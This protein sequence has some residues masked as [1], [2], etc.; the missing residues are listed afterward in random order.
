MFL[1]YLHR[2]K[3]SFMY[4]VRV[5]NFML[6]FQA[7]KHLLIGCV[8]TAVTMAI[9]LTVRAAITIKPVEV[10]LHNMRWSDA[11]PML[12]VQQ[13]EQDSEKGVLL[14][15]LQT[16]EEQFFPG[17][18]HVFMG[19]TSTVYLLGSWPQ[20]SDRAQSE[21][22]VQL[23]EVRH[24]RTLTRL[25]L[26][27]FV[28]E[29]Y[30]VEENFKQ[31]YLLFGVK[32]GDR[33]S[34]CVQARDINVGDAPVCDYVQAPEG[35]LATWNPMHDHE[36]VFFTQSG[37]ILVMDPWEGIVQPV[38][39][40]TD[41]D[42][43]EQLRGLFPSGISD[44][45]GSF[46]DAAYVSTNGSQDASF[47]TSQTHNL[48]QHRH[49][50]C[51]PAHTMRSG[52]MKW[53]HEEKDY[54]VRLP[55]SSVGACIRDQWHAIVRTDDRVLL[56]ELQPKQELVNR[57]MVDAVD[58]TEDQVPAPQSSMSQSA[59]S[60]DAQV[61]LDVTTRQVTLLEDAIPPDAIVT[62]SN[63]QHQLFA[64][65]EPGTTNM[66]VFSTAAACHHEE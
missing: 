30:S 1:E 34:Y 8:V 12:A 26:H 51:A 44:A 43:F 59:V 36:A 39:A 27:E 54:R 20:T 28:G 45:D 2:S 64:C 24:G 16:G 48:V 66:S 17:H 58:G 40:Q 18:W 52:W 32:K 11:A 57:T 13:T 21:E 49:T 4:N 14:V 55:H 6:H 3:Q 10:Q 47:L 65:Q 22:G 62:W 42:R 23:Y 61:S 53:Q 19:R 63:G 50:L 31:T 29:L 5:I 9:L 35:T 15:H 41:A 37:D 25:P 7:K 33:V 60:V 46:M 38:S 56:L